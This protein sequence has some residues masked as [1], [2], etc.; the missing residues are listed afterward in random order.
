MALVTKLN[1]SIGA[2]DLLRLGEIAITISAPSS[3][4]AE[5]KILVGKNFGG[6]YVRCGT[7]GLLFDDSTHTGDGVKKKTFATNE[8]T[9]FYDNNVEKLFVSPN[10]GIKT[11]EFAEFYGASGQSIAERN[12]RISIGDAKKLKYMTSL[13]DLNLYGAEWDG[14][15]ADLFLAPAILRLRC[16]TMR[17]AP[18]SEF[19][20]KQSLKLL[21]LKYSPN[22]TGNVTA[23]ANMLSL[24]RLHLGGS[25]IAGTAADIKAAMEANG[26]HTGTMQFEDQYFTGTTITFS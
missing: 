26:R 6:Q 25:N 19:A 15:V 18:A 2:E 22:I 3:V 14:D 23:F 7:N 24:E 1:E 4:A 20:V 16:S 13:K 9:A 5:N 8:G 11:L 12:H 10:D 17:E 21:D